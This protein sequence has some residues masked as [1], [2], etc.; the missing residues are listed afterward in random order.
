MFIIMNNNQF[1]SHVDSIHHIERETKDTTGFSKTCT[2]YLDVS[3]NLDTND[4][5]TTQLYEKQNDFNFPIVNFP[6]LCSNIPASH[7]YG[8]LI[9][10]LIQYARVCSTYDQF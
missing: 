4:N 1:H 6:Y 9:S 2:S 5:I 8:V 3:L 10:Q 7:S